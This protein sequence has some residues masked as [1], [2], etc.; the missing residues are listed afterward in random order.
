MQEFKN[1]VVWITGASS[2]IG[3]EAAF[4]LHK[5]GAK[6]VL[7]ARKEADLNAIRKQLDDDENVAVLPLDITK[8]ET[9]ESAVSRVYE[10]FGR[11]D[12]LFNIAGISQR[13][14]AIDTDLSVDRKIMEINY[15]GTIGLTKAVLPRMLAAGGGQFAVVTSVTG[16]FGF[17]VRSAYAASKH[18]L[19]G[20]FES[21]RI[22]LVNRGIEV[23]MICPGPI[24]TDISKHALD[25]SGNPT[26]EMD[27]MQE[28]GLPV[29]RAVKVMLKAIANKKKEI[30]VGGFKEKLGVKVKALMP[31][32]FF[33][34]AVK[35]NPRGE[36][37]L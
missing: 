33:K 25:G 24:R 16:K 22:E 5:L 14:Y 11:V 27:E 1:K 8:S 6:L 12:L 7:S 13:S 35:Q 32:V 29:D 30:V 15:F 18:A 3:K 19:H 21:L 10:L 26:G 20:F 28:K 2:G 36:L 34:M 37:K 31:E 23:T 9:F 17:G 4:Q